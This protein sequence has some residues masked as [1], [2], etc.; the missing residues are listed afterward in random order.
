MF[1]REVFNRA[2]AEYED[3][4]GQSSIGIL[5]ERMLHAVIKRTVTENEEELEV[6]INGKNIADAKI[7]GTVYEI[8]TESLFPVKKKLDFYFNETNFDV[9]VVFPIPREKYLCWVDSA[10]GEASKPNR[11]TKKRTLT[12]Y[13]DT[14]IYN[15]EYIN[16]PRFTLTL[17]YISECEYRNLDGKRSKDKKRGSTRIER[18]PC[19]L[20]GVETLK[21]LDD[22]AKYLLPSVPCFTR[23]SYAKEK[24]LTSKRK[25]ACA[26]KMAETLG[27]AEKCGKVKNEIQYRIIPKEEWKS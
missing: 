20:L 26:L 15:T 9:N 25:C 14:L 16:D 17:L 11:S 12:D 7:G 19:D 22:F 13:A 5:N 24:K 3:S 8:Q 10:S 27:I 23:K 1:E 18:R 2:I 4:A 6:R 21:T